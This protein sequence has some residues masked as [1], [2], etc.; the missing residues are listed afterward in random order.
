MQGQG[1]VVGVVAQEHS[2]GWVGPAGVQN[3]LVAV[4]QPE[5]HLLQRAVEV[6]GTAVSRRC[7]AFT[8]RRG[9]LL[10]NDLPPSRDKTLLH[11]VCCQ[12]RVRL[13]KQEDLLLDQNSTAYR[14]FTSSL[15]DV[16]PPAESTAAK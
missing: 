13:C 3:V 4:E 14:N 6:P 8:M 2:P 11:A 9:I 16:L 12:I 10:L 7:V 1:E 15:F 5:Q